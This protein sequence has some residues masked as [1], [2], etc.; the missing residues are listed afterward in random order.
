M[1]RCPHGQRFGRGVK[2]GQRSAV[3]GQRSAVSGR[4]ASARGQ[5]SRSPRAEPGRGSGD[6]GTSGTVWPV[7]AADRSSRSWGLG[8]RVDLKDLGFALDHGRVA[9]AVRPQPN[10]PGGGRVPAGRAVATAAGSGSPPQPKGNR[11]R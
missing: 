6:R 3:S 4:R 1:V 8:Q 11:T 9:D 2:I 10:G 5:A 7:R